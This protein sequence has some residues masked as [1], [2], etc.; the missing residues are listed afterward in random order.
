M[1]K[2]GYMGW[3]KK[4]NLGDEAVYIAIRGLLKKYIKAK[5]RLVAKSRHP[6]LA[7]YDFFIC[8]GGT[9]LSPWGGYWDHSIDLRIKKGIRCFVFGSGVQPLDFYWPG[10]THLTKA[11]K[12]LLKSNI[13]NCELVSVRT[14]ESKKTLA[15]VGCDPK[16][17]DVVGDP[18]LICSE[19]GGKDIFSIKTKRKIIGINIGT[20]R[21]NI[22]GR[23]EES[24]RKSI[25]EFSKYLLDK[26]RYDL[27]FFPMWKK[28]IRIQNS[29][30]KAIGSPRHVFNINKLHDVAS[31][32]KLVKKFDFVIGMKLHSAVFAAAM[33]VPFISIAYRPKCVE[34]SNSVGMKRFAI[35]T[36]KLNFRQLVKRFDELEKNKRKLQGILLKKRAYYSKKLDKFAK[37]VAKAIMQ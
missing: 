11:N 7:R 26:E 1:I 10:K 37:K 31:T 15:N 18:A 23:N 24:M 25:I 32:L 12:L 17:I 30:V 35:R 16:R 13:D 36:D 3:L 6:K 4:Y 2:I 19:K 14:E 5:Y 34:F 29:V 21:N 22:L 9:V 33:G 20:A 27:V 8:G 28:D